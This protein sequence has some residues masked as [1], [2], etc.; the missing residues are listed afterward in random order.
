VIETASSGRAGCRACQE[1]IR[2]GE[3]RLGERQPNPFGEGEATYW[4]HL[5]C[6]AAKV[7]QAYLAALDSLGEPTPAA[8]AF[9]PLA[10]LVANHERLPRLGTVSQAPTGRA[11][12]RHCREPIA[13]GSY[14]VSLEVVTEGIRDAWGFVHA[15]CAHDYFDADLPAVFAALGVALRDEVQAELANR[16]SVPSPNDRA[17]SG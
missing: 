12:C 13:K 8:E 17:P 10:R 14:R 5:R 1:K 2:K 11:R 4:F 7:P 6:G 15:R 9:R 16:R 3:L